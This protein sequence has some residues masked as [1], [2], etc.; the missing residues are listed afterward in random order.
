MKLRTYQALLLALATTLLALPA[1]ALDAD[2]ARAIF[3]KNNCV[4]CH[5]MEKPK[6]GP[7]LKQIA[8]KYRGKEAEGE[9]KMQKHMTSSPKVKLD[10][11]TEQDHKVFETKDPEVIKNVI[12]WIL[13]LQ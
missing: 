9:Q 10:D 3:K 6:D 4:K 12:Q 5:G 8:E 13:S 1:A 11:G 2:A 7:T